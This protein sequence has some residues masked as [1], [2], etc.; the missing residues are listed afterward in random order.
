MLDFLRLK[1]GSDNIHLLFQLLTSVFSVS[2]LRVQLGDLVLVEL[3]LLLSMFEL[4]L[5]SLLLHVVLLLLE[6]CALKPSEVP[7]ACF[8]TVAGLF[9]GEDN[10]S[11]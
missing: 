3:S 7:L 10:L 9:L 2:E 6:R 1:A 8:S 4:M 11:M 5:D